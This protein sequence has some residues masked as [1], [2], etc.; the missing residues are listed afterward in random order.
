MTI[1]QQIGKRIRLKRQA[2]DLSQEALAKLIGVG[3]QAVSRY[4]SGTIRVSA[5]TLFLIG[6]AL[7]VDAGYFFSGIGGA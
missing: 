1:D 6:R 2:R 3:P 5:S 4:E 7:A